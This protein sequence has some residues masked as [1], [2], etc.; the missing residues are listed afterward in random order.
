MGLLVFLFIFKINES[1]YLKM[2]CVFYSFVKI[3]NIIYCCLGKVNDKYIS[4][5]C[6]LLEYGLKESWY[7]VCNVFYS[8]IKCVYGF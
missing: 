8:S 2:C 4:Y 1:I 6:L 3:I 5:V 7:V